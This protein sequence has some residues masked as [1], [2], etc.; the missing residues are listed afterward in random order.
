MNLEILSINHIMVT[1]IQ[2]NIIQLSITYA[3]AADHVL[4]M[5]SYKSISRTDHH[6]LEWR[7]GYVIELPNT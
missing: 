5:Q 4:N 3:N 1:Q 6:Q 7:N 2:I